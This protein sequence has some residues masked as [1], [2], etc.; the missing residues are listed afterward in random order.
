MAAERVKARVAWFNNGRGFGFIEH[1]VDGRDVFVHYSSI[2]APLGEYRTLEK[3]VLVEFDLVLVD[4]YGAKE[5][6]AHNVVI[7]DDAAY[8]SD[9]NS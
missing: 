1:K 5:P 4:R 9:G 8:N 2:N 3:G 6:Q 7:L